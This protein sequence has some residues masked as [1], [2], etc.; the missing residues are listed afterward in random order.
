MSVL[1]DTVTSTSIGNADIGTATTGDN[2]TKLA[3]SAFVIN[4]F[5]ALNYVLNYALNYV[6]TGVK[7]FTN[8]LPLTN[9]TNPL[10]PISLGMTRASIIDMKPANATTNNVLIQG[11]TQFMSPN[12]GTVSATPFR[13]PIVVK[14]GERNRMLNGTVTATSAG[15]TVVFTPAFTTTPLMFLTPNV[16]T[17]VGAGTLDV[18][19]TGF[20]A[21]AGTN[22]TCLWFALGT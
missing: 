12:F 5:N 10:F 17:P 19:P 1:A 22:T 4:S 20:K 7:T 8:G 16:T 15:A 11:Q 13:N 14:T 9:G 21:H 3:S 18:S 2:T 6:I